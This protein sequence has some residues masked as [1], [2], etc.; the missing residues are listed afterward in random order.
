MHRL[1]NE[2]LDQI[3][4]GRCNLGFEPRII[5]AKWVNNGGSYVPAFYGAQPQAFMTQLCHGARDVAAKGFYS[6]ICDD[7]STGVGGFWWNEKDVLFVDE[8]FYNE[9]RADHN[10]RF[11]GRG[12]ITRVAIDYQIPVRTEA[13]TKVLLDWFPKLS[14]IFL[15]CSTRGINWGRIKNFVG[16]SRYNQMFIRKQAIV[17]LRN[18][19]AST[20]SLPITTFYKVWFKRLKEAI[21]CELFFRAHGLEEELHATVP[22][23]E[24]P[25]LI[26]RKGSEEFVHFFL[27]E[28]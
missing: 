5:Q 2:I 4:L 13:V 12:C 16:P 14:Q 25:F 7:P 3:W 27:Y 9:L 1:P 17:P 20:K 21:P 24:G 22:P 11:N 28:R 23:E 15:L 6:R 19:S 18:E 26:G 10:A 8:D